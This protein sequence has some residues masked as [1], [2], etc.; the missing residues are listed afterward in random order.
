M[1][2]QP[3]AA[4]FG[5]GSKLVDLCERADQRLLADHVLAGCESAL[6]DLVVQKRRQADVDDVDVG[7]L[8]NLVQIGADRAAG[9]RGGQL[10]RAFRVE[11]ADQG[12]LEQLGVYPEAI[13]VGG[14]DPG[15]DDRDPIAARHGADQARRS[16]RAC[17][18]SASSHTLKQCACA[19][20][21]SV[22]SN[23]SATRRS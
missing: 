11:I 9:R 10:A 8:E 22:R 23:T 17:A 18:S 14:P 5:E 15:A 2:H 7:A 1:G 21:L 20:A 4:G 13:V 19:I 12:D 6:R 3:A 16:A